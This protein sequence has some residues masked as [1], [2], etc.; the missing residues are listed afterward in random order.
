MYESCGITIMRAPLLPVKTALAL[1]DALYETSAQHVYMDHEWSSVIRAGI[2]SASPSLD[3]TLMKSHS[4]RTAPETD[5][6]LYRAFAS[7]ILRMGT[8]ATPFAAL[9]AVS[10]VTVGSH[11]KVLLSHPNHRII[12]LRADYSFVQR[13]I[14]T[15]ERT[16]AQHLRLYATPIRIVR[17]DRIEL[18]ISNTYREETT[19]MPTIRNTPVVDAVMAYASVPRHAKDILSHVEQ[20]FPELPSQRFAHLLTAMTELGFLCS[21]LRPPMTVGDPLSYVLTELEECTKSG[22]RV[23][24]DKVNAATALRQRTAVVAHTEDVLRE[25]YSLSEI[26]NETGPLSHASSAPQ[27]RFAVDS[28]SPPLHSEI[29]ESVV[30]ECATAALTLMQLSTVPIY[31]P[32]LVEYRGMFIERYG[33]REVPVLEVLDEIEGLGPPAVYRNPPPLYQRRGR[34]FRQACPD[35]NR[36]VDALVATALRQHQVEVVL[37]DQLMDSLTVN[38]DWRDHIP[39]S[40][41]ILTYVDAPD[42]TAVMAGNFRL[43][44]GPRVGDSPAWRSIGRFMH[45]LPAGVLR[46]YQHHGEW[47]QQLSPDIMF[48]EL[49]YSPPLGR[50]GNVSQRPRAYPYDVAIGVSPTDG[51][52]ISVKDINVG[53]SGDQLYLRHAISGRR[54]IMRGSHLLAHTLSPNLCRFMQE[55]SQFGTTKLAPFDWGTVAHMPFL[56]RLRRGRHIISPAKWRFPVAPRVTRYQDWQRQF[57]AWLSDWNVSQYVYVARDDSDVRVLLDLHSPNHLRLLHDEQYGVQTTL[58]EGIPGPDG[59]WVEDADGGRYLTEFAVPLRRSDP[60]QEWSCAERPQVLARRT[61]RIKPPG[62]EW[63]YVKLY[64][65]PLQQ[66]DLI[67]DVAHMFDTASEARGLQWFF[68]RYSDPLPHIRLRAKC[69]DGTHASLISSMILAWAAELCNAGTVSRVALDTYDREIDRYGGVKVSGACE[70]LF[71][72]DSVFTAK[73]LE[74]GLEAEDQYFAGVTST[75]LLLT[76]LGI[77]PNAVTFFRDMRNAWAGRYSRTVAGDEFRKRKTRFRSQGQEVSNRFAQLFHTVSAESSHAVILNIVREEVASNGHPTDLGAQILPSIIHM[78]MNRLGVR[79]DEEPILYD[80]MY[81]VA[82][83]VRHAPG[84]HTARHGV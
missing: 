71:H 45:I 77:S 6:R 15:L 4:A 32:W 31:Q 37:T 7:Y 57:Q 56:P 19:S 54:L 83:M 84:A 9:A 39:N 50:M 82:E 79:P 58:V 13:L 81:R 26:P 44:I 21:T 47:E 80:L 49:N 35:R 63:V 30:N 8:R 60:H 1:V 59:A 69:L 42:A 40:L 52:P 75:Q 12:S 36:S 3:A 11:A 64:C 10:D 66:C 76:R 38:R 34:D 33:T 67:V 25:A 22:R 28:Y 29:P 20:L 51:Y 18:I 41:D 24:Q 2:L 62:T 48:C 14:S 74:A 73:I 23:D 68:V 78:H 27:D 53:V 55:V 46:E 43:V 70:S 17:G 72:V 65:S 16:H 5:S 61:E